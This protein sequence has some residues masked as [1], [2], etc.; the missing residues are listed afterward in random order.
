MKIYDENI[1][2]WKKIKN[3]KDYYVSNFGIFL[4]YLDLLIFHFI[5]FYLFI[6]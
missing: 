1:E 4:I 6:L 5:L 2:T 3:T